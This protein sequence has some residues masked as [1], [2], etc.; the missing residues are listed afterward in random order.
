MGSRLK[1]RTR[2]RTKERIGESMQDVSQIIIRIGSFELPIHQ[3]ILVWLVICLFTGILAVIAGNKIEKADPAKAPKG[4]VYLSE[5]LYNLV[6]Y[7]IQG[8]LK[9]KT[10]QYIPTFGTLMFCM[11]LSN[12]VGLTGFQNPTSN[13]SFNATLALMFFIL[14]QFHSVKKAGFKARFKELCEPFPFLLPLNVIGDLALPIS[15]TMRLFG[16]ILAGTIITLLMYTLIKNLAPWGYFGLT[17][18]PFI[19][20]YFDVFSGVIQTYI[21][22]TLGTFFLGQQVSEEQD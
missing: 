6:L 3:S 19:H 2:S 12:L 15:L 21:F 13:V 7:V 10:M 11:L 22:F 8:N 14:I 20:A 18:T 4:I 9:E 16:N 17:L 5:E 1:F